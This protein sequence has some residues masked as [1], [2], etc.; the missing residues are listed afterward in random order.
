[1]TTAGVELITQSRTYNT[2]QPLWQTWTDGRLTSKAGL[3]LV[4]QTPLDD[5]SVQNGE[6]LPVFAHVACG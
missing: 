3:E 2:E 1:M 4:A 6:L 5:L